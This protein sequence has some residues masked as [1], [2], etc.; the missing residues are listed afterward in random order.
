MALLCHQE[1]LSVVLPPP[2]HACVGLFICVWIKAC[3][4]D[5][6]DVSAALTATEAVERARDLVAVPTETR[7]VDGI[8]EVLTDA[9][10]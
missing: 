3:S 10:F 8:F 7:S 9:S 4:P 5:E 1:A 6:G 2:R